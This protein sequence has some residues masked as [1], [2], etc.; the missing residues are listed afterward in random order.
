MKLTA[1]SRER[2]D[3]WFNVC[4]DVPDR[5]LPVF[6]CSRAVLVTHRLSHIFLIDLMNLSLLHLDLAL[7]RPL[8]SGLLAQLPLTRTTLRPS[9]QERENRPSPVEQYN[10]RPLQRLTLSH[11]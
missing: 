1:P 2:H 3:V 6:T 5:L 8:P 10:R 9:L 7:R 4:C 11:H